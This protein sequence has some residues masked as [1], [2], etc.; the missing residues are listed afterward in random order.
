MFFESETVKIDGVGKENKEEQQ[1]EQKQEEVK[2][3]E[4]FEEDDIV[5]EDDGFVQDEP[6]VVK[7]PYVK[8]QVPTLEKVPVKRVVKKTGR[9]TSKIDIGKVITLSGVGLFGYLLFC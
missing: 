6:K 3:E 2:E 4:T 9:R 8:R 5:F 7:I 1:K